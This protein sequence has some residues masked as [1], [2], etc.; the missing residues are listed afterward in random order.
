MLILLCSHMNDFS[1]KNPVG[2]SLLMQSGQVCLSMSQC[3][4]FLIYR[5]NRFIEINGAH[6]NAEQ[7]GKRL[8][9]DVLRRKLG[10]QSG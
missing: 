2:F 9:L 1:V 6:V 3:S 5:H 8:N 7:K 4:V 10:E